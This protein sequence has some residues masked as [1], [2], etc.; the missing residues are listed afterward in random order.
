MHNNIVG[1]EINKMAMSLHFILLYYILSNCNACLKTE[2]KSGRKKKAKVQ[3]YDSRYWIDC[4]L[5]LLFL[6]LLFWTFMEKKKYK[7]KR[8][9]DENH[10]IPIFIFL[11]LEDFFMFVVFLVRRLK[12]IFWVGFRIVGAMKF[13]LVYCI[14]S[15]LYR[16]W[17][18][19]QNTIST[20]LEQN[21]KFLAQSFLFFFFL[22]ESIFL[23]CS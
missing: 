10:F 8:R 14:Y 19:M 12:P 7:I 3:K 13:I 17:T 5:Q 2:K 20:R 21:N 11:F 1:N 9:H 23:Q 6:G 18:T 16:N 22:E 15:T 4:L